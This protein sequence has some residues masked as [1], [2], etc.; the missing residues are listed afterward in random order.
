MKGLP[1]PPP[2]R[3]LQNKGSI[4]TG[5]KQKEEQVF[6]PNSDISDKDKFD[7]YN[8]TNI[9]K[10]KHIEDMRNNILNYK[11]KFFY[12]HIIDIK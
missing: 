6:S 1:N 9:V 5:T 3:R 11:V 12:N 2:D 10:I 8:S 4:Q 7:K